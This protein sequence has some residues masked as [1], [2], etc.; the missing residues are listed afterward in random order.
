M[1]GFGNA[2]VDLQGK[3]AVVSVKS[4]NGKVADLNLRMPHQFRDKEND[5]RSVVLSSLKRGKID[6][7]IFTVGSDYHI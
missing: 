7:N 3:R 6:L 1:T 5:I 4:V 2:E